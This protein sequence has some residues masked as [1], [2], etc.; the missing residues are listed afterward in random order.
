M[1]ELRLLC[2]KSFA[3]G[4]ERTGLFAGFRLLGE[5][6]AESFFEGY[7]VFG[8]LVVGRET[9]WT[10]LVCTYLDVRNAPLCDL[11]MMS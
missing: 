10:E 4:A 2:N 3:A 7:T 1:G 6:Q 11:Q 8:E 5:K 9:S